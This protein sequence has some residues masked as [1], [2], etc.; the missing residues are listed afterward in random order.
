MY[1]GAAGPG[2]TS[3]FLRQRTK[4]QEPQRNV[5]EGDLVLLLERQLPRNEWP[6]GRVVA[7]QPGPDGLVRSARVRTKD[8]ELLRPIAK[9]CV[10][11][12][13]AIDH[14]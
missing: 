7:V 9:L 11:E 4:W 10:L 6:V 1:S 8:T 14:P 2:N 13:T 12:E 5:Q 3:P